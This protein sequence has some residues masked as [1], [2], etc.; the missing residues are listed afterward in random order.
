MLK[1]ILTHQNL[2]SLQHKNWFFLNIYR[3]LKK[4]MLP[5]RNITELTEVV[6]KAVFY[7]GHIFQILQN[8]S[9]AIPNLLEDYPDCGIRNNDT[10]RWY[11]SDSSFDTPE[12]VSR[13]PANSARRVRSLCCYL[14][15]LRLQRILVSGVSYTITLFLSDTKQHEG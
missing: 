7:L 15:T 13:F 1:N 5:F 8:S 12:Y 2:L 9:A 4:Q 3:N 10:F 11:P 14:Y 6:T